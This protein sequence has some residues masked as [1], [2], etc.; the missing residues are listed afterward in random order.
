M[1][2][3]DDSNVKHSSSKRQQAEGIYIHS[4]FLHERVHVLILVPLVAHNYGI[5]RIDLTDTNVFETFL[6]RRSQT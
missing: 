1:V 4:T 3:A 6:F 2:E 5:E